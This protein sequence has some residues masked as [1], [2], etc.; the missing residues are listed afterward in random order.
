MEETGK[1]LSIPSDYC[2]QLC[3]LITGIESTDAEGSLLNF[4]VAVNSVVDRIRA[5]QRDGNKIMVIGNGGSA[6]I[7]S[8]MQNDLCKSGG[9]RAQVFY[10]VPLY[11]AIAND[12][13]VAAVF[14]HPVRLFSEANDVLCAIS[15][16]GKSENILR[17]VSAARAHGC[18]VITLSGFAADNPLRKMGDTNF[19]VA[20]QHYGMVELTHQ[21]LVH[22][23]TDLLCAK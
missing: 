22:C 19:Y 14:E 12:H 15:S 4:D 9:V 17:A 16:S 11:S 5:A 3:H 20:A 1:L 13:S 21:V 7:A 18:T 6:S 8:H 2:R 10:D 23:F